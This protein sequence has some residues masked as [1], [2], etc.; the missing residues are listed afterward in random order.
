MKDGEDMLSEDRGPDGDTDEHGE[1]GEST[2][3]EGDEKKTETKF[4]FCMKT[5]WWTGTES[6]TRFST[7]T[8]R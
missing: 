7:T 1:E 6:I 3:K 5:R 2:K 8:L 4:P